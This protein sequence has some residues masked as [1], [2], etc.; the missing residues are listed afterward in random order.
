M[1]AKSVRKFDAL[2]TWESDTIADIEARGLDWGIRVNDRCFNLGT[3]RLYYCTAVVATTSTWA[4]WP[5]GMPTPP[6]LDAVIRGDGTNWVT[7]DDWLIDSSGQASGASL[8]VTGVARG[9]TL[10]VDDDLGGVAD[11][12]SIT[13]AYQLVDT[14]TVTVVDTSNGMTCEGYVKIYVDGDEKW[15]AYFD[16]GIGV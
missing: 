3:N 6:T 5:G 14:G 2:R 9:G 12:I 7:E 13:N 16:E 4:L 10:R 11:T 1:G 8:T 15:I